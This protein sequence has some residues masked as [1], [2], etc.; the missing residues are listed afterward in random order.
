M[1]AFYLDRKKLE[2][3]KYSLIAIDNLEKA[4][5]MIRSLYII[6]SL[7]STGVNNMPMWAHYSNNH[8]GYCIE[9]EIVN[10]ITIYPVTYEKKRIGIASIITNYLKLASDVGKRI[11]DENNNEFLL[12]RAILQNST[13]IKHESWSYENEYRVIIP[14][15]DDLLEGHRMNLNTQGLKIKSI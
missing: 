12:Y 10:P 13:M 11:I 1:K 6:T 9:F 14:M 15:E 2:E 5:A 7:T 4:L 3:N 8:T